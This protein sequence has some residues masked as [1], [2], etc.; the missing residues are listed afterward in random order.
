MSINGGG[1]I[2]VDSPLACY[3]SQKLTSQQTAAATSSPPLSADTGEIAVSTRLTVPPCLDPLL[4]D[5][6]LS[7]TRLHSSG[8]RLTSP[9]Q[10]Q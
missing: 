5:A 9:P 1:S 2:V 8:F 3:T 4:Y 6:P 7:A 10:T